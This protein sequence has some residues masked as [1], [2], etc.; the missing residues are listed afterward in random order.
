MCRGGTC[1]TYPAGTPCGSG[2]ATCNNNV[3]TKAAM[4]CSGGSCMSMTINCGG[5]IC[6][7]GNGG[8]CRNCTPPH[9]G[10][11]LCDGGTGMCRDCGADNDWGGRFCNRGTG[12]CRNCRQTDCDP[13]GQV[14]GL[15]DGMC[16]PCQ[17]GT[18][19]GGRVCD[20]GMCRD[21]LQT[22]CSGT[23]LCTNGK[24]TPL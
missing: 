22:D 15:Q 6:D 9:C 10:N 24:C 1:G 16:H 5:K 19:C 21:C 11:R 18:D 17:N 4:A 2:N 14:C 8:S 3:L 23:D 12:R 7:A 13:A 20:S